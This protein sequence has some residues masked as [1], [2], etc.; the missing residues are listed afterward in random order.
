MHGRSAVVVSYRVGQGEVTWWASATPLTNAGIKESGNL[1]LLL[2]SIGDR[3]SR[4]LWDEYFHNES[5]G[6]WASVSGTP[7]R[8]GLA[9]LGIFAA[10]LLLTFSRRSGPVRPLLVESRLSPLEFVRTLG[11]LYQHAQA[12]PVA[13]D[14]A[15]QRF[16]FLLARRLGLRPSA[17]FDELVRAVQTRLGFNEPGFETTLQRCEAAVRNADL[18]DTE[19]V[20]LTQLLNDYSRKLQLISG[21]QQE[22]K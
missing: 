4:V 10:A 5:A 2:N 16:R 11:G 14:A 20:E 1:E 7:L 15:Y 13:V 19:A 22:N 17:P 8:W 9:Q 3:N 6:L 12:A 21:S 18:R